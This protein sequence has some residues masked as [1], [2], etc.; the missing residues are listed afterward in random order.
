MLNIN[1]NLTLHGANPENLYKIFNLKMPEKIIDFSSN[2]NV[3]SWPEIDIDLRKSASC[4][5]DI[6]CS[7]LREFIA[8][9]ENIS[10]KKILFTNGINEAIFILSQNFMDNTG[11]FQPS[12]SEYQ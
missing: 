1:K 8:S 3:I 5:P 11:I 12:Y 9:H 4:Y 6:N 10:Q 2:T 7:K